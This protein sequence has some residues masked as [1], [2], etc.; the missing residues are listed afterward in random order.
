MVIDT[1]DI[2]L[3]VT[4]SGD[5]YTVDRVAEELARRG[6]RARRVDSDRFPGSMSLTTALGGAAGS[7][8]RTLRDVHGAVDGDAVRAVWLRRIW[9]AALDDDLDPALRDGCRRESYAAL[10]GFLDGLGDRRMI[11]RLN[12][13]ERAE[14]KLRQ[15]RLAR[16]LGLEIPRTLVT[17]D[18][19][20]VLAFHEALGCG[21]ITKML[22]P[23]T[24][25]MHG[26]GAFVQTN[27]VRPE[28]LEDLEGLCHSP[29]VFQ[30]QVAKA[31]ELRVVVIAGPGGGRCFAGAIDAT[32]SDAGQVDWR[33]AS[34]SQVGWR[35][36]ALPD[37]VAAR[38]LAL[39][40]A[41]DLSY[42]AV[43]L[44]VTPDG[45]HVFLEINPAGEWGM[46]ERDIGLPIAA[47]LADAL[48]Q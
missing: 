42:G 41:L 20:E 27:L 1:R 11:N 18:P 32:R 21:M 15:L 23:L 24:Q 28:D 5:H 38:L 10:L 43:D 29:M 31:H 33:A 25:S 14:N 39:A 6:A 47:A 48:L 2:V 3:L 45:R 4:H 46:L 8:R 26:T 17:N 16:D 9:P 40:G 30:E 19:A 12:A 44:I 7:S 36:G 22:T 37:E 34:R 13:G 35:P